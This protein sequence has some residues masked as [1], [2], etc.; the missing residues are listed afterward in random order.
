MS[1]FQNKVQCF[2]KIAEGNKGAFN[3]FFEYYYPRLIQFALVYVNSIQQ[4]EDVV[5]EVLTKMLIHRER[6]FVMEHCEA[7]IFTSVKNMA[8]SSIKKDHKT[9]NNST[10]YEKIRPAAKGVFD[11]Y[12]LLVEKELGAFVNA[13]IDKFPPKRKMVY[14]LIREQNFTYRQVADLMEISERT[15]EVHLK[16]AIKSLREGVEI[17][18]DRKNVKKAVIDLVK[19][20]LPMFLFVL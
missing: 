7:Y 2:S 4:A 10:D 17:Y 15:V 16:L 1:T 12:E 6:V 8:L 9:V 18:Q 14:Q 13:I 20:L 5:A 19:V 3:A 11:P